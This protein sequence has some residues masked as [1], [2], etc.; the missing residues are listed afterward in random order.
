MAGYDIDPPRCAVWQDLAEGRSLDY[1][2]GFG[3][4]DLEL[5][6]QRR[7]KTKSSPILIQS[8]GTVF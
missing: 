8:D 3:S 2:A 6:A 4:W 1:G 5:A 7:P